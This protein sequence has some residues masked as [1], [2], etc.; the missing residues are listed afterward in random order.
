MTACVLN[1]FMC[2]LMCEVPY[3]V[4]TQVWMLMGLVMKQ[5]CRWLHLGCNL[6]IA[7]DMELYIKKIC[8]CQLKLSG[9]PRVQ[10]A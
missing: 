9:D 10:T 5:F 4:T 8:A 3:T 1:Q 7:R 2:S 6:S